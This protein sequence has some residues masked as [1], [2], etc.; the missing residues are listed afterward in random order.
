[1]SNNIRNIAQSVAAL[2]IASARALAK[3]ENFRESVAL[4]VANDLTL[5]R[6]AQGE[7]FKLDKSMSALMS[8]YRDEVRSKFT[9]AVNAQHDGYTDKDRPSAIAEGAVSE[10]V[11]ILHSALTTLKV[12]GS[13]AK[14]LFA[15]YIEGNET[16]ARF[17]RGE[18][19][20]TVA[21]NSLKSD[22]PAQ[23]N[24]GGEGEGE[25]DE[26]TT[27]PHE[28]FAQQVAIALGKGVTVQDMLAIIAKVA[29]APAMQAA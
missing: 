1:M 27:N 8:Q 17:Y 21:L 6:E 15:A 9:K 10:D 12:R 11:A 5:L 13:E 22:A 28:Q 24:E 16:V 29:Q 20:V 19:T 26:N 2:V 14:R 23:E 4:R 3:V 7:K 25:G 18:T